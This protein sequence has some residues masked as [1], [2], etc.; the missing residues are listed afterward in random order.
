[1]EDK[2]TQERR[3]TPSESEVARML[4]AE[5]ET[6]KPRRGANWDD[7]LIRIAGSGPAPWVIYTTASA[8]LVIILFA[9]FLVGSW[10]Q[11]GDL[12]PQQPT[13]LSPH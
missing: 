3:N 13:Q 9:A 5:V 4:R 12:A 6:W 8:A 7:L 1:M 10:L 2:T 11:I